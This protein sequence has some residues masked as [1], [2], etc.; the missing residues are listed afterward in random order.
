MSRKEFKASNGIVVV[1]LEDGQLGYTKSMSGGVEQ[2][3]GWLTPEEVSAFTEF[4]LSQRDSEPGEWEYQCRLSP[5]TDG[6][7]PDWHT[8]DVDHNC[9]GEL[10]RRRT[11]EWE[12]VER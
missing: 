7:I 1:Q 10:R 6:T 4:V 11:G 8:V 2:V 9:G 3:G 5:Y 12:K